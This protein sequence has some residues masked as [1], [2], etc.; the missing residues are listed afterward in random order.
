[1]RSDLEVPWFDGHAAHQHEADSLLAGIGLLKQAPADARAAIHRHRCMAF[2]EIAAEHMRQAGGLD[3]VFS[4]GPETDTV[5]ANPDSLPHRIPRSGRGEGDLCLFF[6]SSYLIVLYPFGIC[7]VLVRDV[8]KWFA[9]M[10]KRVVVVPA[11]V[12][13]DADRWVG[14]SGLDSSP[15]LPN[16]L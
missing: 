11:I 10:A 8:K 7:S 13:D 12:T 14:W 4:A 6:P 3:C 15:Q 2:A 1:M 9:T 16:S 5:L